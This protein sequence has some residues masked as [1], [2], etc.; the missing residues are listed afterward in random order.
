MIKPFVG[1]IFFMALAGAMH[2][3]A[4]CLA[5]FGYQFIPGV[6]VGGFAGYSGGVDMDCKPVKTNRGIYAGIKGGIEFLSLFRIEEELAWQGNDVTSLHGGILQVGHASGYLNIWS[7]MSNVLLDFPFNCCLPARPYIGGGIG[8]AYA[9]GHWWAKIH[10]G[11]LYIGNE[12][13]DNHRIVRSGI[14]EGGFA[15]QVIAGLNFPFCYGITVGIEYRYFNTIHRL[16]SHKFG[17]VLS[18]SF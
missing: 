14:H 4:K 7:L 11:G 13:G 2:L 9:D 8:G 16:S 6:Y 17:A 10:E 5:L 12:F 3:P 15:W 1:V 18:K